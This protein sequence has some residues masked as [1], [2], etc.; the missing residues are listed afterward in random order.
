MQHS[1]IQPWEPCSW[2]RIVEIYC[3]AG[4]KNLSAAS[5]QVASDRRARRH[6][7]RTHWKNTCTKLVLGWL[8]IY[9]T[10]EWDL[11]NRHHTLHIM[12]NMSAM[13]FIT[14]GKATPSYIHWRGWTPKFWVHLKCRY[15]WTYL[16]VR[17]AYVTLGLMATFSHVVGLN[18]WPCKV[19]QEQYQF[20]PF[21]H[22]RGAFKKFCNS[23]W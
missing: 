3:A 1:G 14:E 4:L 10:W 21:S 9:G 13:L 8:L 2:Q 5:E 12:Q 22:V 19:S 16:Y 17:L 18:R 6:A 11:S 20:H 23:I 7:Y 15:C